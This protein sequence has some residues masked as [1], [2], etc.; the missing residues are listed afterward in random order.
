M[1]ANRLR[2]EVMKPVRFGEAFNAQ[3]VPRMLTFVAP[4]MRWMSVT[5]DK[6][7]L[8]TSDSKSLTDSMQRYFQRIPSAHSELRSVIASGPFVSTI[9]EARWEANGRPRSQ[10]SVG[11]YEIA[12][13]RIKNV[14]YFPAHLC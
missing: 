8:E 10:C 6:I 7:G 4:D 5:G 12:D 13:S 3:D 9:E 1:E 2:Q 11:V 14:W